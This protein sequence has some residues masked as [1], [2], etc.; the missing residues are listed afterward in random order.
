MDGAAPARSR[1]R[2]VRE[3]LDE[4]GPTFVKFGQLLST[5]PD[6]V[7]PDILE[8]LR[9]LQDD[10]RP[11]PFERIRG[12]VEAAR[13]DDR[14]GLHRVRRGADGGGVDRPGPPGRAPGGQRVVVKVQRPDAERQIEA[15][16]QLLYQAA[17]VAR[18][19]IQRLQFIDLVETVDEFARTVRRELDYGIEARNAEV[20]RRNF[21]GDETVSLPKVYW[22]YTTARVLTME[23]V[24]GTSLRHLDL[25]EWTAADRVTLAN[26]ITQTWMQMVFMDGFFHADPHPA[27]I[28]VRA[29]TASAWSTAG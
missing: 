1:A 11:E 5:R 9:G 26:R 22:R 21:A 24:E 18:E 13:P 10:A 17:K 12:V 8:E 2:R 27:N 25:D 29:R 15:D 16:I 20:F 23:R 14:A 28:L 4:P 3:M 19:R 6:I 7:P